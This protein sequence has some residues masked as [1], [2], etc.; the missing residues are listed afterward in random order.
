[1]EQKETK[2]F[3]HRSSSGAACFIHG[4]ERGYEEDEVPHGLQLLHC[5]TR[6][7]AVQGTVAGVRATGVSTIRARAGAG[8]RPG[9]VSRPFGECWTV[10]NAK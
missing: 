9:A 1:M 8:S 2:H 5:G 6:R 4:E 7:T 10:A 3:E